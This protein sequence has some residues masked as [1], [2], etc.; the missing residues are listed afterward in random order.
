MRRQNCCHFPLNLAMSSQCIPAW[1]AVVILIMFKHNL[2]FI[3]IF[4][5]YFVSVDFYQTH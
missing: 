1:S 3:L 4:H 2:Q 5:Y